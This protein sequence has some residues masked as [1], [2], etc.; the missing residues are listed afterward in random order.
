[1]LK[2]VRL[3]TLALTPGKLLLIAG[4]CVIESEASALELARALVTIARAQ[5]VDL[6]FK[7]SYD[8]ANRTSAG[9]FRGPGAAEGLK[10][11][12]RIRQETGVPVLADVHSPQEAETAGKVLDCLQIPALLSRQTD[13]L[14]AAAKTGRAVNIKK[15]QFMAPEDAAWAVEKVAAHN[16]NILITER[17]FSFGYHNLVADMRS[18]AI[19]RRLGYPVVFDATHSVQR[20]GGGVQ[21]GG[22]REFVPVLARAAAGAGV[23]GLFLEVHPEPEKALSDGASVLKLADL[24]ALLAAVVGIHRLE[25]GQR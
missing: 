5:D 21:S 16:P 24:P 4:P 22:E 14:V 8:K 9:S 15:G 20:P 7:A 10:I 1:V 6:V 13:L 3:G 17:G 23:D 11:L 12:A 25:Q 2:P 19:L 18:L